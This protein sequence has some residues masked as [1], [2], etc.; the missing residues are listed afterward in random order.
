MCPP[1]PAAFAVGALLTLGAATAVLHLTAPPTRYGQVPDAAER[2]R[3]AQ[4]IDGDTLRLSDGRSVRLLGIDAPETVNPNLGAEQPFGRDASARLAQLVEGQ[5]V[6]LERD[7]TDRD[8]YGRLLRHV[9]VGGRLVSETLAR[10]GLAWSYAVPPDLR[11]RERIRAAEAAAR[12]AERGL[13]GIERPTS[14][15]VFSGRQEDPG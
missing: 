2:A 3:V 4:V 13:W 8:H 9:W 11:H 7:T 14:L 6:A 15:P 1:G 12:Q 10:E 5:D